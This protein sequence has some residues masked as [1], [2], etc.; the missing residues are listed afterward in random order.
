MK[1]KMKTTALREIRGSF[2]RFMAILSIIALGVGFFSG[3][4]ITTPAMVATIGRYLNEREFYDYRLVSTIGWDDEDIKTLAAEDDVRYAE[5]ANSGDI[6]F[7]DSK[8]FGDEETK[9]FVLKAHTMPENVNGLELHRGRLPK[10]SG[11]CVVDRTAGLKVGDKI[12][13]SPDNEKDMLDTLAFEELRV[14]G[15]VDSSLYIHWE[16]GSTSLGNGSVRGYIYILSEDFGRDFYSDIYVRFDQ[17]FDLY[18]DE[19][20]DYMEEHKDLWTI[21][22]DEQA[23]IRYKRLKDEGEEK[24]ADG[25]EQL[26]K[27]R[28]EGNKQL[29]DAKQQLD[30]AKEQL[31]DAKEQLDD[32]KK[33]IKDN[34]GKLK[35]AKKELDDGEK[36]LNDAKEQLDSAKSQISAGESVLDASK[37][38][39]DN[40]QTKLDIGRQQLDAAE[41]V[42][43]TSKKQLDDAAKQLEE[44]EQKLSDAEAQISAAE[45]EISEGEA[46]IKSGEAEIEQNE[47]LIA[48]AEKTLEETE[49]QYVAKIYTTLDRV[50]WAL[51]DEQKAELLAH[52]LSTPEEVVEAMMN[53]LTAEQQSQLAQGKA[54]IEAG[55]K[56]I[57]DSKKKLA[58]GKKEVEKNKKLIAEKRKELEAGKKEY[59][60]GLD[61]YNEGLETYRKSVEEYTSGLS[62]YGDGLTQYN[63]G[64]AEYERGLK[65]YNEGKA[66]YEEKKK[67]F[68]EGKVQYEE[69]K[70]ALD[71]GKKQFKEAKKQYEDGLEKYEDGL[72]EYKDGKKELEEK[73]ADGEKEIADAEK[74]LAKL[75]EPSAYLLDRS[76]NLG[77]ACFENDSEIVSQVARVFPVF[78]VLVAAL[79]C[80]T[81]MSR[82]VEEQ[83]TQIGMFKALGYSEAAIMGKFVFYSGSA[84]LTGCVV[85]YILGTIFF[86]GAIWVN[87][88]LM[89]LPLDLDYYFSPLTAFISVFVSLLC[90]VGTTWTSCRHELNETA[91]QLMRPKAPR[92]G[93]RVLLERVPFIWKHIRFLLKVSIRNIFRYKKRLFMM[94]AGI[95]GCTALL[96]TGFGIKDSVGR[97]GD[98]QFD[99]ILV[100][101]ADMR[102]KA[103]GGGMSDEVKE[104]VERHC[105]GYRQARFAAWNLIYGDDEQREKEM[106]VI[107]PESYEDMDEFFRFYTRDGE[108][109][110]PPGRNE[111]IVS[112]SLLDRYKVKVGDEITLRDDKLRELNLKVTGVFN[113]YIYNYVFISPETLER[114]LGEKVEYNYAYLNFKEGEDEEEAVA[115]ITQSA[116]V[117]TFSRHSV[118]RERMSETMESLNYVV[119]LIIVCAAGLA[120]IVIYNLTNINITERMREIATIKVLGFFRRE[121]SAYVLRENIALTAMGTAAGL[122]LGIL[123]HR[124][125]MSQIKVDLVTFKTCILPM[126]YVYSILLTFAF[127]FFVN[128][129]MELKLDR[130]N[131]AESLKS[132]D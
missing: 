13:V 130:I 41:I 17:D 29:D 59:Q 72:K 93:K 52:S 15:I 108:K 112:Y 117:Q 63:T 8:D 27:A 32:A 110:A 3:V 25:K 30:D 95:S 102:Y 74:K 64:K 54:Q 4:T 14:V 107:A 126:S 65:Q 84:A 5:G 56:Q 86:P 48:E 62:Q 31:D 79:V 60:K 83:R 38:Q 36:K 61:Q 28:E 125:A 73:L 111:A 98:V 119:L 67:Q 51:N 77:Y 94:I 105:D 75:E 80:M 50:L 90:S 1:S 45:K 118:M 91:A 33:E 43:D 55:K 121:T 124:F 18:S 76:T 49:Q 71:E 9:E 78:F 69:G 92:A 16:R 101:S 106:N 89:Y 115:D 70:K 100:A 68:D 122:G 12:Y 47:K 82:M 6:L 7:A 99:E 123:L 120:F 37:T 85:G 96:L 109:I 128:I 66:T 58:N 23:E 132:V 22:A 116:D 19:Y 24:I 11:E 53:Y 104:S 114:R 97:F 81:T 21:I 34:S 57:A 46:A 40:A 129:F 35:D 26:E 103:R 113:N 2:G 44:G 42:L 20:K 88:K 87:Y 131:M 39:L 127:N 10:R